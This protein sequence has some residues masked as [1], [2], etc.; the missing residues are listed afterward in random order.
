M[1]N[2]L[3]LATERYSVRKFKETK[4][5]KEKIRMIL[6]AAKAAPTACNNQPQ[7]IYVIESEEM[8]ENLK[9]ICPCTFDAPVIFAV[10]YDEKLAAKGK[11][12]EHFNFGEIDSTI[13]CTTMMYEAEDLGL[14]SC[15]VGWFSQK[16]IREL[17]NLPENIYICD[18]LPV[19]YEAEDSVPNKMH[20]EFRA[21]EEIVEW[22]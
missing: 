5:E 6:D 20:S 9:K 16:Q 10:G 22:L 11:I 21:E 17:L 2:F 15:W 14:G 4:V 19:G 12:K 18:L 1:E 8:R 7:K 13:V 3:T